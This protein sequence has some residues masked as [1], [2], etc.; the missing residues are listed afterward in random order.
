MT[1]EQYD[2]YQDEYLEFDKVENKLSSR[3]DLHAFILLDSLVPGKADI[4]SGATHD[5][6][7]LD[8]EPKQLAKV[9]TENQIIELIRCGV[10]YSHN[11]LVMFT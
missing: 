9:A 6:I 2:K 11:S 7:W 5:E 10:R 3:A 8:I 4:V 1:E